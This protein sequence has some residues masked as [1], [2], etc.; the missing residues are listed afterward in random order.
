[1]PD[2][3]CNPSVSFRILLNLNIRQAV[4]TELQILSQ[5]WDFRNRILKLKL[6]NLNTFIIR[7]L[8]TALSVRQTSVTRQLKKTVPVR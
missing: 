4:D 8:K 2:G 5:A 3:V 6:E 1:M 7:Q